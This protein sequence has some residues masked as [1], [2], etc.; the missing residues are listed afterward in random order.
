MTFSVRRSL[1]VI[2]LGL[3]VLAVTGCKSASMTSHGNRRLTGTNAPPG[4]MF[5]AD[6]PDKRPVL[7]PKFLQKVNPVWWFGNIDDPEPPEDYRPQ[8]KHRTGKWYC[9]NSLHNFTFYV[10][11]V[12]DKPFERVGYLEEGDGW[13]W[14]VCKY[15]WLRLP[16][17]AYNRR[18]FHFYIGWRDRGNFGVKLNF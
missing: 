5:F 18:G 1:A 15:K 13:R 3:A 11:G 7:K 9:R 4:V 12:A 2:S 8:D 10:V 6:T 16:F 17:V 14:A